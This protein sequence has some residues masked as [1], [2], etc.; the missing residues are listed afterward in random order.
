MIG[1]E[2]VIV[3]IIRV[4]FFLLGRLLF[5]LPIFFAI[6]YTIKIIMAISEKRGFSSIG[7]K[8][9]T[10]II[11]FLLLSVSLII[12]TTISGEILNLFR[13]VDLVIEDLASFY[14]NLQCCF[15][16]CVQLDNL[17][18]LSAILYTVSRLLNLCFLCLGID[19]VLAYIKY[20][21]GSKN[22]RNRAKLIALVITFITVI[23]IVLLLNTIIINNKEI[24]DSFVSIGVSIL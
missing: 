8:V 6:R 16:E 9:L 3:F 22:K 12:F 20:C 18:A 23:A 7:S 4:V 2:D 1:L 15:D 11:T 14:E 24:I 10:I 17:Y 5:L 19:I 13:G 21:K